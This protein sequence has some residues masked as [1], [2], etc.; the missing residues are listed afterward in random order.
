MLTDVGVEGHQVY[1]I[2]AECDGTEY[3][4]DSR[5]RP[6]LNRKTE[7]VYCPDCIARIRGEQKLRPAEIPEEARKINLSEF[8]ATT[9]KEAIEFLKRRQPK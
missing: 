7:E 9:V 4:V 8:K 5:T 6:Y 2:I 3:R 1:R